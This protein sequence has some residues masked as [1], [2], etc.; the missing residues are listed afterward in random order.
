MF[1]SLCGP[2]SG[3]H[4]D[5][6]YKIYKNTFILKHNCHSNLTNMNW[7]TTFSRPVYYNRTNNNNCIPVLLYYQHLNIK[8]MTL[9]N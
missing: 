6:K 4:K 7:Q 5:I 2:S 8:N 1:Q 3:L 9:Y